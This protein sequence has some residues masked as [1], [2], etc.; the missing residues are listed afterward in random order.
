MAPFRKGGR[1]Q[2]GGISI[3]D[4]ANLMWFD[5]ADSL[6]QIFVVLIAKEVSY[7]AAIHAN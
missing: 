2:R 4:C 7:V 5:L 6:L 3:R 1:A